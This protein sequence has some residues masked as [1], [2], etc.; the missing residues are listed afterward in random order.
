MLL[1]KSVCI[2]VNLL[3][4]GRVVVIEQNGCIRAKWLYS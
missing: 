1:V 2:R 3:Y 4:S